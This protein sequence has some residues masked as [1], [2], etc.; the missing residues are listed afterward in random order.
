[1]TFTWWDDTITIYNKYT[2]NLTGK[3]LWFR[4]VLNNC[5]FKNDAEHL[6]LGDATLSGTSVICRI[7]K[8]D[9]YLPR[10]EWVKLPNDEMGNYFTLGRGDMIFE[11]EIEDD[12]DE[13]TQGKRLNDFLAK[14]QDLVNYIEIINFTDNTGGGRNNEHY[15]VRGK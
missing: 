9:K 15:R 1:M 4:T 13:Y 3:V 11:G 8:S 10:L 6:R 7:P 14:Y 12:I 2:D 5:F